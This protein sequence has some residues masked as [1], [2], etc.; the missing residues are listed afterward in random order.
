M[1]ADGRSPRD[2]RYIEIIGQYAP[3]QEPSLFTIDDAFGGWKKAQK[4]HFDDGG[5][6]SIHPYGHGK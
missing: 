6:C 3:R 5:E 4:A 1:V 2:G